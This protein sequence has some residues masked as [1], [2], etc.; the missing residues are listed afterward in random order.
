MTSDDVRDVL[1]EVRVT[2]SVG[3]I[4]SLLAEV[5]QQEADAEFVTGD[6]TAEERSRLC[7]SALFAVGLGLDAIRRGT[8][9]T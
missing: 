1:R 2:H 4:L 6:S 5:V 9:A 3:S 7:M 8:G